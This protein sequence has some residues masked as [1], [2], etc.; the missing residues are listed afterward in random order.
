MLLDFDHGAAQADYPPLICDSF[1]GGGGASTGIEMALGR[2]PDI[3]IN[4]NPAALALHAANHPDTLHLSENVWKV[5]PLDYVAG[6][7]VGLAWFS[8]DCKH[9][10]KAKGGKP[11]ERNIRDL[12]WVVVMWAERVRPDV[13]MLENV[14]EFRDWGPLRE[15]TRDGKIVLLPDPEHRGRTFREWTGKLK[16][17]GYKLEHRELR[18]CDYGA[19]TIRKRLF[20]IARCDGQ[21][22]VWPARTHGDPNRE[23][24]RKLIEAGKLLPYRT[25]AEII[26]WSLPCPSLFDTKQQIWEKFGLRAI[27][28]TADATQ[29]R[30]AHGIGR[31]VLRAA[32]D[33]KRPFLVSVAHGYSGGRREYSLDETFGVVTAGGIAH[34]LVSPTLVQSGYGERDGQ[35]PRSLNIGAPLGTAVAGGVKHAVVAPH[36]AAYYGRGSGSVDRSASAEKPVNTIVTENRHALIVPT[37]IGCGGRAG[38]SRPRGVDEPT[39]TG[40]AKADV[41]VAAAFLAQ[42]NNDDRRAGGVNPGRPATVPVSTLTASPQQGVVAAH[43]MSLKGSERRDRP[44]NAPHAAVLA[45]GGHSAIVAP[46]IA[47]YYGVEQESGYD[48][49]THTATD[50]ARFGHVETEF[51]F[52][53]FTEEQADRAREVAAFLR[54]HGEWDGREFVTLEIDGVTLVMVDIGMR[55]LKA[56]ELFN[57]QGFPPDYIIDL[58]FN[59]KPLPQSDQ[60][61]CCGNSVSPPMAAALV[62]ANCS[63]LSRYEV[64][65]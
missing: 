36:L 32:A 7:H 45:G 3:A 34:A 30:V 65:A 48:E 33:G 64:A 41:C 56:R 63:H 2:S 12:A 27:R 43:L 19:P 18:A 44:A 25:A 35:A 60:I 5:D 54:A 50:K 21:P 29:S 59:G 49:P 1:A 61:S 62:A 31:Y 26:D 20:L 38:Q 47:K 24:D 46:F 22:I 14:E 39:A 52:P 51:A 4:H 15:E 8:P 42:H 58:E 17:L 6:R 23:D 55:M 53:P 16:R 57:A 37:L 9:F 13:I 40:T 28:P 10:S 11:V